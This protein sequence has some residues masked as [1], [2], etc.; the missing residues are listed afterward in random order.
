MMFSYSLCVF[1]W[2][3]CL[4]PAGCAF[5]SWARTI[6]A[7]WARSLASSVSRALIF[8]MAS[9]LTV[10]WPWGFRS[11]RFRLGNDL[12]LVRGRLLGWD[13]WER[14]I[15]P[16]GA[17]D[18]LEQDQKQTSLMLLKEY[19]IECHEL[20]VNNRFLNQFEIKWLHVDSKNSNPENL[21]RQHLCQ[22]H[23]SQIIQ[24]QKNRGPKTVARKHLSK[25]KLLF[26]SQ[27]FK[28][29]KIGADTCPF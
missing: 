1:L 25:K 21:T 24:A 19:D 5:C 18:L 6:C 2:L 22:K 16:E 15:S 20:L 17:P 28:T 8:W 27:N 14:N 26:W 12:C 29:Q 4:I 23:S 10:V 11:A 9:L 3:F 7:I 13:C